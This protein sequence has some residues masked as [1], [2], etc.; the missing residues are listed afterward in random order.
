L[1]IAIHPEIPLCGIAGPAAD[2]AAARQAV[3]GFRTPGSSSEPASGRPKGRQAGS[4]A[5]EFAG[6]GPRPARDIM[7]AKNNR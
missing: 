5:F 4:F 7:Q 3:P 6:A 2:L 1:S